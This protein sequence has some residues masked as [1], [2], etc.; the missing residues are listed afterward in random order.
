[1]TEPHRI[2]FDVATDAETQAARVISDVGMAA[3]RESDGKVVPLI[4]IDAT[5][6]PDILALFAAHGPGVV[7]ETSCQWGF[8]KGAPQRTVTLFVNFRAPARL[9]LF[10]DFDVVLQG[11]LVEEILRANEL[12]VQAIRPVDADAV[13]T[14]TSRIL[15]TVPDTGFQ[16]IWS[17][18][19][20]EQ[21]TRELQNRGLSTNQAKARAEEIVR[22]W[23][24]RPS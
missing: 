3:L 24:T 8:R 7:G 9:L 18:L 17:E 16:P 2:D 1:L 4:Q 11:F 6:R 13:P 20:S 19:L 12:Y 10:M 22:G 14:S 21:M 5:G 23:R 15:V